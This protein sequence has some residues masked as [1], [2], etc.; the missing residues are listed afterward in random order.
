MFC[1]VGS[2]CEIVLRMILTQ[3]AVSKAIIN[4]GE[5]ARPAKRQ[6]T[7]GR[8]FQVGKCAH[9]AHFADRR[10]SSGPRASPC[11]NTSDRRP[12]DALAHA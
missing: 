10:S 5:F 3:S 4:L 1:G 12:T 6:K 8:Y 2:V 9:L 11:D 7:N